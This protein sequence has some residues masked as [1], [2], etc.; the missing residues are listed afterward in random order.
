MGK[1]AYESVVFIPKEAQFVE[2]TMSEY[3]QNQALGHTSDAGST[4][5][6]NTLERAISFSI[7]Q[8]VRSQLT[9]SAKP[10]IS[11]TEQEAKLMQYLYTNYLTSHGKPQGDLDWTYWVRLSTNSQALVVNV[12][13]KVGAIL[14]NYPSYTYPQGFNPYTED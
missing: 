13:R 8:K 4:V 5:P 9:N 11:F 6:V 3:S 7:L 1:P 2:K 10:P 14:P 12:L